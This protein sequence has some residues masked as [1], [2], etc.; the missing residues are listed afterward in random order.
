M[1]NDT[2]Q[3][4]APESIPPLP[5][6]GSWR[7]E[8]GQWVSNDPVAEEVAAHPVIAV[9]DAPSPTFEE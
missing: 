2:N 7:W 1:N 6:G 3:S 8:G 4:D 9:P 5:G